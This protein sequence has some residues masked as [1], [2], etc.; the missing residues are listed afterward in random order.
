MGI[1]VR[2]DSVFEE[3]EALGPAFTV[4]SEIY[5]SM[6][7]AIMGDFNAGCRLAVDLSQRVGLG[8]VGG[9]SIIVTAYWTRP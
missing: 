2:P 6:V 4:T 1:H 7:G 5:G 8:G 9:L 3:L